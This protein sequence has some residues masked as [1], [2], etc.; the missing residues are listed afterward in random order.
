[1]P[2]HLEQKH[3]DEARV[4]DALSHPSGSK[5][6]KEIWTALRREGDFE[7][8]DAYFFN[9]RLGEICYDDVIIFCS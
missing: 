2:R 8:C 7:I 1:M 6:R 4:K 5:G 3:S 9:A